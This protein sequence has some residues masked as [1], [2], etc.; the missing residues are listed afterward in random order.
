MKY[1]YITVSFGK[2]SIKCYV[3][4]KDDKRVRPLCVMLQ[5]ISAYRKDFD[6]DKYMSFLI[7]NDEFLEKSN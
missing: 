2:K 5:K 1:Y 6:E 3:G 4:Y 7:K